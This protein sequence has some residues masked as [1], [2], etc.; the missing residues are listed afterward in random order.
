MAHSILEDLNEQTFTESTVRRMFDLINR[1]KTDPEFQ[2]L[3]YGLVNRAM[4]GR[5]KDY[6]RELSTIFNWFKKNVDY[7]RDPYGVELLQDVWATLDRKR[8][9]CDDATTF[10]A[11]AAEI[12]GSPSRIVTVS[13]RA[14]QEPNH[15]YAEAQVGGRWQGL[16]ATV[17]QSY[18]GWAP[19]QVTARRIW[20]RKELGLSGGEEMDSIEGLGMS[21]NGYGDDGFGTDMRPVSRM[22]APGVRDDISHTYGAPIPGTTQITDRKIW[23]APV[24]NTSDWTSNPRPGGG[25]YGPALPIAKRPLPQDLWYLVDRKFVP[26][27]LDPDNAWWGK[28]PTS[29]EDLNAMFPGSEGTMATYLRDIASVPASAIAE[30]TNDVKQQLAMGEIGMGDLDAAIEEGL[31]SYALGRPPRMSQP[32]SRRPPRS[33]V[34]GGKWVPPGHR[35][36]L[37]AVK[38]R[39][40]LVPAPGRR[41]RPV[42]G[43]HMN[44]LGDLGDAITDA[45]AILSSQIQSGQVPSDPSAINSA[46]NS[47]VNLITGQPKATPVS[48]ANVAKAAIPVGMIALLGAAAWLM[49]RGGGKKSYRRNPG[50][51]RSRGGQRG[52]GFDI[53]KALLWG[54]GGL[55][56]YLLFLRPGGILMPSAPRA[57]TGPVIPGVSAVRQA[58]IAAGIKAAPGIFDSIA[59][60]FGGGSSGSSPS[61][62]SGIVTSYDQLWSSPTPSA[63]APERDWSATLVV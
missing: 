41:L 27:V 37:P 39:R 54:G 35:K 45:A 47:V 30:V 16:D 18:V 15:V 1:A 55:A 4:P 53:T 2:K 50:R 11:A 25:V 38:D 33:R 36:N 28:V 10:L 40:Y 60:L 20:T 29:Q 21:D 49:S 57:T 51:R 13:T 46:I 32:P 63:P 9:D 62:P 14:N 58:Q 12:L 24:A 22:L 6:K 5:W 7:R 48:T 26:K 44:G 17:P 42:T 61:A 34:G 8:A 43:G 56:A 31:E 19:P 52:G 23:R 59:K 3:I